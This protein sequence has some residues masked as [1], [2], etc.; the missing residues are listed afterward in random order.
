MRANSNRK[1]QNNKM[2]RTKLG[3]NGASPL[4]LV[5]DGRLQAQWIGDQAPFVRPDNSKWSIG[6]LRSVV[7]LDLQG[8]LSY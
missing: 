8:R 2:Q 5:L 3:Q 1:P 4:I 6:D 7:L